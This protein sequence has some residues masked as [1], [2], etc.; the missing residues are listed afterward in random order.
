MSDKKKKG[1][2]SGKFIGF[3]AVVLTALYALM[4]FGFFDSIRFELLGLLASS[5]IMPQMLFVAAAL[6]FSIIGLFAQ[7]RMCMF[8]AGVLM[9]VAAFFVVEL[10]LSEAKALTLNVLKSAIVCAL[11]AVFLFFAYAEMD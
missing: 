5:F 3:I 9:A 4:L 8:A 11:P 1:L 2:N 7:K 10:P 6:V